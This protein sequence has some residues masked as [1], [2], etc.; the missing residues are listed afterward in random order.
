MTSPPGGAHPASP[1]LPSNG[2]ITR[3]D[4]R[5]AATS[6]VSAVVLVIVRASICTCPRSVSSS[7]AAPRSRRIA[8]SEQFD[9]VGSCGSYAPAVSNARSAAYCANY[10]S[11][12]WR[13]GPQRLT[14]RMISRSDATT[15]H[16]DEDTARCTREHP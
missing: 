1:S 12:R 14:P 7:T 9:D 6:S 4:E 5:S 11:R 3:N 8:E 16:S 2:P 15:G 10:S 13:C